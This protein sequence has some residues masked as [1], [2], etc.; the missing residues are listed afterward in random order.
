MEVNP[1]DIRINYY[2][3]G[4]GKGSSV[5]AVHSPTGIRIAESIPANS[6]ET[7]RTINARLLS[8]IKTRIQ[9]GGKRGKA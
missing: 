4:P 6:T 9:K 5:E 8:A 2:Y 1:K 3:L 7:G